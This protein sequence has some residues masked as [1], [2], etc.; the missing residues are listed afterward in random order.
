VSLIEGTKLITNDGSRD[1]KDAA[2]SCVDPLEATAAPSSDPVSVAVDV[3]AEVVD[4][5]MALT[6]KLVSAPAAIISLDC[7]GASCLSCLHLDS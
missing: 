4:D 1:P 6:E 5:E 3:V 7:M 2:A